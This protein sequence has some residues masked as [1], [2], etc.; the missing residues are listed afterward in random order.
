MENKRKNS[1]KRQ[2]ILDAIHSTTEHPS[3]EWLYNRLKPV[4]PDLSLGTI[5]RNLGIFRESGE[6]CSVGTVCGQERF[7]GDTHPHAHFVCRSCGKVMD[8][9]S[10][11]L[12]TAFYY[13]LGKQIGAEISGYQLSFFGLCRDCREN[14]DDPFSL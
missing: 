2:A 12:G 4:Y 3:A 11:F 6:I 14:R 1:R 8:V 7:D 9:E 5:Y 13:E 10:P